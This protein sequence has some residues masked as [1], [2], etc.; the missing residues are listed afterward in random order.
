MGNSKNKEYG[1]NVNRWIW[2]GLIGAILTIVN[3]GLS[4]L[5]FG[6][7]LAPILAF[8]TPVAFCISKLRFPKL[9]TALIIY[10]PLVIVSIFTVNLGP[11]GAYKI[12][13]LIGALAYDIVCAILF[14]GKE[15]K[16]KVARGKLFAAVIAYVLGLVGAA[17]IIVELV[18]IELPL[19]SR[20]Y[21]G[22]IGFV[23]VFSIIGVGATVF[24]YNIYY[25]WLRKE[26]M[27]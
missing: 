27:E 3:N 15:K 12:F 17:Y 14:V 20:S 10:T 5:G 6:I 9:P 23:I 22:V 26:L 4:I 25:K 18:T 19:L 24:S 21:I 13:Y 1:N 7:I 16:E 2:L 11:P 8:T